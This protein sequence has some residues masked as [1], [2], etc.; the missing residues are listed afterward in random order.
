MTA[1]EVNIDGLVGPTHNFAGLSLGNRASMQNA[2]T[3]SNPKRAALQGLA[4]MRHLHRL[5]V[6]QGIMPPQ[7]RPDPDV[8]QQLGFRP[9][10][11]VA[12]RACSAPR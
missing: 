8:L 12:G 9:D 11:P 10:A 7:Q 4:K 3:V 5:G 1:H 2:G 6:P